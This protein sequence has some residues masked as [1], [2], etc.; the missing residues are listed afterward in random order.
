MFELP[1]FPL[2]LV[3]FPMQSLALH[4]FEERYKLMIQH[5]IDTDSPFGVVLLEQGA[6]EEGRSR[7]EA[8]PRNIGCT[9][10]ISQVQ[11]LADGRMN[12]IVVGRERFKVLE[13]KHDKPYFEG[14]V[15]HFPLSPTAQPIP[16]TTIDGLNRCVTRYLQVLQKAGRVQPG[17]RKLPGDPLTLASLAAVL[18]HDVAVSQ[19]QSLLEAEDLGVLFEDLRSLYRREIVLLDAMLSEPQ[20]DQIAP[21]SP[22]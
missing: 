15:E 10:H 2:N 9:A 18:L 16:A 13:F 19:R 4:V 11:K 1:L 8:K 3:L 17:K 12:I 6:A 20:D 21:F 7:V 14:L 22:N 5:C